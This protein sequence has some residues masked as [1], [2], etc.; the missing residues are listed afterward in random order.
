M[1][2]TNEFGYHSAFLVLIYTS[3]T[4][5]DVIKVRLSEMQLIEIKARLNNFI[6]G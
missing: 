1:T 3:D 6:I 2:N 5:E 4:T